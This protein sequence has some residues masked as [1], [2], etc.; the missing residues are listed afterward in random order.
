MFL[1]FFIDCS[2]SVSNGTQ[3]ELKQHASYTFIFGTVLSQAQFRENING[4]IYIFQ[5]IMREINVFVT[6]FHN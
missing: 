5:L 3:S 4:I 6:I 1:Y 2:M